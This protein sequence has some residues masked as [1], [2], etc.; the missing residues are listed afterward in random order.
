LSGIPGFNL[1]QEDELGKRNRQSI[2]TA[3]AVYCLGKKVHRDQSLGLPPIGSGALVPHL[4]GIGSHL[5]PDGE[6][7]RAAFVLGPTQTTQDL[8][9]D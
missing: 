9:L 8:S 5:S 4:W 2:L 1:Q 7:R 6:A 3:F